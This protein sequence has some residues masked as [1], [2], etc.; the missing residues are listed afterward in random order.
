MPP[1]KSLTWKT[2]NTISWNIAFINKT[3]NLK[4]LAEFWKLFKLERFFLGLVFL[5]SHCI[6]S[7][8]TWLLPRW[9]LDLSSMLALQKKR[10]VNWRHFHLLTESTG[11]FPIMPNTSIFY[12]T[13]KRKCNGT[14]TEYKQ[15]G[16]FPNQEGRT[17]QEMLNRLRTKKKVMNVFKQLLL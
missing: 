8:N 10:E 2:D 12:S 3:G 4:S 5:N 13:Y 6:S 16:A 15:V 9:C 11:I 1:L 7:S 17:G 14:S